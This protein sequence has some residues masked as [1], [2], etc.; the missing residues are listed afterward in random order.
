M[1]VACTFGLIIFEG[2]NLAVAR[3]PDTSSEF[4]EL[5]WGPTTGKRGSEL[6]LLQDETVLRLMPRSEGFDE[7]DLPP[8][9]AIASDEKE[10]LTYACLDED[11]WSLDVHVDAG[12]LQVRH[13]VEAPATM[14]SVCLARMG[15]A[16]AV[17]FESGEVYLTR[18][19]TESG[20]PRVEVLC[21]EA[22]AF[23]GPDGARCSA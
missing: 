16:L 18:R 4:L 22:V 15:G 7:L 19:V 8:I 21:G 10:R 11:D 5:A 3:S 12:S 23:Q 9:R 14:S 13:T 1:V 6:Y 20:V 2:D 17:G